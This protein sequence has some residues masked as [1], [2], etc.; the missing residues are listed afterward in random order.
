M[1]YLAHSAK[2]DS[3]SQ[4][5][6]A[7][8]ESVCHRAERYADEAE[9]YS[10]ICKGKL[11]DVVRRSAFWHDLGKLDNDNQAVLHTVLDKKRQ[12]PWNHTDAGSAV[13]KA[14]NSLYSALAVYSHHNGLPDMESE[15]AKC[16]EIFRD[17]RSYVRS[18]VDGELTELVRRHVNILSKDD[19]KQEKSVDG[20]LAVYFRM[21]LSCLADA[22][23]TDT[24]AAYGK[25]PEN[26]R[27]PMLRADERLEILNRYVS[28][29]GENSE[30]SRLRSE[31]YVTCRDAKITGAFTACDSP[32]GSGK[33]TAVMAHLL[34][35]A[36][37]RKA[38]RIFVVLPFTNIIT[39]SV[40]VYRKS[41]T[42]P[43]ENPD[44]IVAELHSRADF[45]DKDMRY[46][47]SQWRAPVIVTTAVAFFE[48]LA[49]NRPSALRRM[50]ELPGSVVFIDEA[51]NALPL[52]LLPLAWRWMNT[53]ADEWSCYWVLASG[54][55]VR[56]WQLDR[57]YSVN[58]PHPA[59][60]ELV[61]EKL[62]DQLVRYEQHRV[63]FRWKSDPLSRRELVE[64]VQSKPGPRLLILNTVQ[65]AA[66][67]A[68][69]FCRIFGRSRIEHLSTALTAEDRSRTIERVKARL[70]DKSDIDWTLVATSCAE[71]G[72]NLSFRNGFR[73]LSSLLSLLQTAGR[74]NRNGAFQ[75]ADMWSF[76][77]Q[78]DSMLKKNPVLNTSSSVLK[79]YLT[80][81]VE[82]TTELSS[83]SMNDEIIRDDSCVK[84]INRLNE[85]EDSMQFDA[86]CKEFVV[87]E[88]NTVPAIVDEK[89]A[90]LIK[91]GQ[92][93][94]QLLQRKSVSIRLEKIKA[95]ELQEIAKGIY[96]W[97]LP[98]NSFLGYMSGVLNNMYLS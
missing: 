7:H 89:F 65:S 93:D 73:E 60:A 90:K 91:C 64:W 94:W 27:L 50:H 36:I 98:Y 97:T 83:K 84:T 66:V 42:L 19:R 76:A 29:L 92:G 8:V 62:H 11:K 79:S 74:V 46:L 9:Q 95:W 26:E 33:T 5:Y 61:T 35:Q 78:D 53:L 16:N 47:T 15:Y 68:E 2:A 37:E 48:T 72:V 14:S 70:D 96:Q 38:R 80:K 12:L 41:L 81:G 24:A 31:M 3:P 17:D 58:M 71:T 57:L 34:K 85:L 22:D 82:I 52:K 44:D 4:T 6:Y 77:L 59:V 56:Y 88:S 49:S 23:H 28:M 43:G 67:I 63:F 55:L 45:Q 86:V 13:L 32:V 69:D 51:H 30:R 75:D 39:Q 87:I 20:N 18:H 1:E 25:A 21:V 54:S 10:S 40:D